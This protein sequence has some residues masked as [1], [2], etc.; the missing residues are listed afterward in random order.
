MP[1]LFDQKVLLPGVTIEAALKDLMS[2]DESF[3]EPYKL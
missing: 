3:S 1:N 2:E